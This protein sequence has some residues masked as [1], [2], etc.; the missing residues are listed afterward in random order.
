MYVL[1]NATMDDCA[2]EYCS[3][4]YRH[5]LEFKVYALY[6]LHPAVNIK[7]DNNPFYD[8]LYTIKDVT[9]RTACNKYVCALAI[10]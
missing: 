2:Y 5:I 3:V 9:R 6:S 7:M 10:R 8:H 4:L 1:T